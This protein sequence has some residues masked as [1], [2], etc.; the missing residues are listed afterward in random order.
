MFEEFQMAA[1]KAEKKEKL[2]TILFIVTG[3]LL[4]LGLVL[5]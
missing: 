3:I 5:I 2:N 1:E 4:T